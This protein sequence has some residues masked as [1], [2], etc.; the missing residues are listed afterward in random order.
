VGGQWNAYGQPLGEFNQSSNQKQLYQQ[1]SNEGVTQ[2]HNLQMLQKLQ[3]QHQP[4][5]EVGFPMGLNNDQANK[6][7]AS[8][9]V[10]G[11][12]NLQQL[13]G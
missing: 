3:Q 4:N 7:N 13:G 12:L 2:L 8:K 5:K 11:S 9:Q 1:T 10:G 6:F